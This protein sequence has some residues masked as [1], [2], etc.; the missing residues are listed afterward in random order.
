MEAFRDS[1][2]TRHI[3]VS[4]A[5]LFEKIFNGGSKTKMINYYDEQSLG[6]FT[7]RAELDDSDFSSKWEE[8]LSELT[9]SR[10]DFNRLVEHGFFGEGD[11]GLS[12]ELSRHFHIVVEDFNKYRPL[13]EPISPFQHPHSPSQS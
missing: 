9:L 10:R 11:D 7:L 6:E 5:E 3:Y 12:G 2:K 4:Y 1:S 8:D 13:T